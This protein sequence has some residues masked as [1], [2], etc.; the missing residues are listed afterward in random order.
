VYVSHYVLPLSLMCLYFLVLACL[1]SVFMCVFLY[2]L[3]SFVFFFLL[4][5]FLFTYQTYLLKCYLLTL[6]NVTMKI[7]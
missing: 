7:R 1:F 5:L 3:F 6:S 4:L 2:I